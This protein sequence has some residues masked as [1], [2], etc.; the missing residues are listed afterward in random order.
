MIADV[1]D[2]IRARMSARPRVVNAPIAFEPVEP[3]KDIPTETKIRV[4]Y[5]DDRGDVFAGPRTAQG[6]PTT[7][8]IK[9]TGCVAL[10][11]ARDNRA[12]ATERDH[13]W[14]AERLADGFLVALRT[15]AASRANDVDGVAGGFIA[16][17]DDTIRQY[18]A[19]YLL[20]FSYGRAVLEHTADMSEAG[21]A[22]ASATVTVT[23]PTGAT[24][25]TACAA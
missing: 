23:D 16:P 1:V 12:G 6:N 15:V 4:F 24:T 14:L 25:E 3:R 20:R 10:I 21:D 7:A 17:A 19:F 8:F 13:R 18:G 5:D 2:D 9:G 22:T 11:E